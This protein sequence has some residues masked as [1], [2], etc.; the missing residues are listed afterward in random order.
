MR[1]V[2]TSYVASWSGENLSCIEI[3]LGAAIGREGDRLAVGRP[4]R[5]NVRVAVV[6][7]LTNRLG[8]EIEQVEIADTAGLAGE[9]EGVPIR[10]P[11][12]AVHGAD[13]GKLDAAFD[14]RRPGVEDRDFVGAFGVH[15]ERELTSVRRPIACGIDEADGVEVR[16]TRR[17]TEL[18]DDLAGRRVADE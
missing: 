3:R 7:E 5:L 17:A 14:V 6:R 4:R 16:I 9:G 15:D 1:P 12:H 2:A 10:R 18:L 11:R 8:L 13:A